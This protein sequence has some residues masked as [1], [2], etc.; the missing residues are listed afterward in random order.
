M[1]PLFWLSLAVTAGVAY[2]VGKFITLRDIKTA[3]DALMA[4]AEEI[5]AKTE[6]DNKRWKAA[7]ER[8][9]AKIAAQAFEDNATG[10]PIGAGLAREMGIEL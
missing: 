7:Q 4:E 2:H 3:A 8:M 1:N 6:A 9:A 10:S 5:M